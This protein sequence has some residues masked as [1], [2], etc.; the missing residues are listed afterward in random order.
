MTRPVSEEAP[1]W[2]VV[3]LTSDPS[4]PNALKDN[5]TNDNA[6]RNRTSSPSSLNLQSIPQ[7]ENQQQRIRKRRRKLKPWQTKL[8]YWSLA[9]AAI[10]LTISCKETNLWIISHNDP[11]DTD[12]QDS[13]DRGASIHHSSLYSLLVHY[14]LVLLTFFWVQ[15]SNPGFITLEVMESVAAQDGWTVEGEERTTLDH[16]ERGDRQNPWKETAADFESHNMSRS[17]ALEMLSP[18][19]TSS[20]LTLAHRSRTIIEPTEPEI[21]SFIELSNQVSCKPTKDMEQ[22]N[23]DVSSSPPPLCRPRTRRNKCSHTNF[24]PPIRSHYCKDCNQCVATFDHYCHFIGTCIGERNH[25]RFYLFLIAQWL[26]FKTCVDIVGSSNLGFWSWILPSTSQNETHDGGSNSNWDSI[27][28]VCAKVYLYPLIAAAFIMMVLHTWLAL[29]NTTT[30]ELEKG[31]HLEYLSG[32]GPC[33]LPFSNRGLC[34]IFRNVRL[35]VSRDAG[36]QSLIFCRRRRRQQQA[37]D[38]EE[39]SWEPILWHAPQREALRS[40]DW[41]NNL[42]QNKYWSCC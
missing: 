5:A 8:Y 17:D 32:F 25:G 10:G 18:D 29:T 1:E 24:A 37:E 20:T 36:F 23:L 7:K 33:D 13:L 3:A 21:E 14:V 9:T 16:V 22:K 30:F 31:H 4:A 38:E 40:S 34:G 15:G 39:R 41:R 19:G 12:N 26:G 6:T 11:P 42:W 35:F 2:E 28:V 27:V